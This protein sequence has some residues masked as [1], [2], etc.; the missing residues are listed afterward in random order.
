MTRTR[1]EDVPF[2]FQNIRFEDT[3]LLAISRKRSPLIVSTSISSSVSLS[4][5]ASAVSA[6]NGQGL[7]VALIRNLTNGAVNLSAEL[8]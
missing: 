1:V 3:K 8:L 4:V 2:E 7:E 5:K 6:E